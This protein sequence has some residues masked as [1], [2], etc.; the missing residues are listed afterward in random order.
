VKERA[1]QKKREVERGCLVV[2]VTK[3]LIPVT[4]VGGGFGQRVLNRLHTLFH[5]NSLP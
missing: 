3:D 2:C 1:K 4:Q 5:Y